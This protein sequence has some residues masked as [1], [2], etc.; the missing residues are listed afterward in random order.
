[1]RIKHFSMRPRGPSAMSSTTG[2]IAVVIDPVRDYDPRADAR[3]GRARS[4]SRGTSTSR[5]PCPEGT[6]AEVRRSASRM[7]YGTRLPSTYPK[8]GK[9]STSP[10]TISVIGRSNRR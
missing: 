10:E 4:G 6:P 2:K 5:A 8:R 3:R 9:I 1:M 7:S